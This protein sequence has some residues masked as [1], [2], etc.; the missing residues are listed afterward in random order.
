M[1]SLVQDPCLPNNNNNNNAQNG[2][3]K[4]IP[5][6]V[7]L[8]PDFSVRLESLPETTNS[9]EQIWQNLLNTQSKHEA[10]SIEPGRLI[11]HHFSN[12]HSLVAAAHLAFKD[13]RPLTLTP[14]D[15]LLPIVHSV[16]IYINQ[17]NSELR[18]RFVKH[19]GKLE[20]LVRRDDF[21]L[22]AKNPWHEVFHD[23]AK[24]IQAHIGEENYKTFRGCFS[25]T[26]LF[27]NAAY[28]VAL[29]DAAQSYF[30]YHTMTLSG[31][32]TVKLLG[33]PEDWEQMRSRAIQM[34]QILKDEEWTK[35]LTRTLDSI[36]ESTRGEFEPK[37][38]E[39]WADF[40]NW[41]SHS[42]GAGI[43]GWINVFF[44]FSSSLKQLRLSDMRGERSFGGGRNANN[45]PSSVASAPMKWTYFNQQ[46]NVRLYAGQVGIIQ[47]S[48]F[49]VRPA[50]GWALFH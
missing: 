42:G 22:G 13:H 14:D 41:R 37:H 1:A 49:S 28:D 39:F 31:I 50:W 5:V 17:H 38:S 8:K 12:L 21:T 45:F 6:S 4:I 43:S 35:E 11:E 46:F 3:A 16:G 40:Y 25:T 32:P 29:M 10:S 20:L 30:S 2:T 48:D 36:V 27:Q 24:Q 33:T 18:E 34:S 15:L 7:A 19:E 26:K 23:F 47:E 44:P 9:S